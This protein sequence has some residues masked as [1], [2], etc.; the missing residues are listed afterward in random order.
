MNAYLRAGLAQKGLHVRGSEKVEEQSGIVAFWHE[1][2]DASQ[3]MRRLASQ[4][5][6]VAARDGAIR[7][8]PHVFN[9]EEDLDRLLAAL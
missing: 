4:D 8:S 6:V 7:V 2:L 9:N 3:E 1:D 5:I